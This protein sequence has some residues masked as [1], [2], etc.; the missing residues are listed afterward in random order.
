MEVDSEN[1]RSV[2][3][4]LKDGVDVRIFDSVG[5]DADIKN[6]A[7]IDRDIDRGLDNGDNVEVKNGKIWRNLIIGW[8]QS[9]FREWQ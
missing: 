4:Y 8:R 2:A 7:N 9:W 6:D 5:Y 1:G 3:K